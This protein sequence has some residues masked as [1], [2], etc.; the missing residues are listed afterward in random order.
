MCKNIHKQNAR[1]HISIKKK[2]FTSTNHRI[3]LEFVDISDE[4]IMLSRLISSILK[5]NML[6]FTN[7]GDVFSLHYAAMLSHSKINIGVQCSLTLS[8]ILS[9]ENFQ[10]GYYLASTVFLSWSNSANCQTYGNV[11]E[12]YRLFYTSKGV[13]S[14]EIHPQGA[15]VVFT[16]A[17]LRKI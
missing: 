11:I 9:P 4:Y 5:K 3:I 14:F 15:S 6:W 10:V 1:P 16:I 12:V 2:N 7:I 8:K 13:P 17:F